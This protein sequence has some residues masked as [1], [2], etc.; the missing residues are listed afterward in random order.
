MKP[1]SAP[2]CTAPASWSPLLQPHAPEWG[3]WTP[4][5]YAE[6]LGTLQP[7]A[8]PQRPACPLKAP[9]EFHGGTCKSKY[10][11]QRGGD[12]G[13]GD[14]LWQRAEVVPSSLPQGEALE[15]RRGGSSAGVGVVVVGDKGCTLALCSH[16]ASKAFKWAPT[17]EGRLGAGVGEGCLYR[18]ATPPAPDPENPFP[19]PHPQPLRV[20][21]CPYQI[22]SAPGIQ[23][24]S[25][26]SQ[27][28][29]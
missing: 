28:S 6:S 25:T 13:L 4:A 18:E 22:A 20:Q 29:G 17:P 27:R 1:G 16:A 15:V 21:D 5:V 11:G 2:R 3:F 19:N 23:G 24:H 26:S 14:P 8:G 12:L 10:P 9:C 7:R